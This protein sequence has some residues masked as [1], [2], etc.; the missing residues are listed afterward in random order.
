LRI[1]CAVTWNSSATCGTVS[2]RSAIAKQ[3]KQ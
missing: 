1:V 2:K 3:A